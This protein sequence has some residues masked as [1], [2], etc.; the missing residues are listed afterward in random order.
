M[1]SWEKILLTTCLVLVAVK[2][3]AD[4]GELPGGVPELH[5]FV[6]Q[7]FTHTTDN[8]VFGHSTAGSLD[9]HELGLATSWR[10]H[11]DWLLSAQLI[12]RNAGEV[13][14][15]EP[16]LDYALVDY[17]FQQQLPGRPGLSLGRIRNP[18]G[19]Y[20]DTRDAPFA[21]PGIVLPQTVYLDKV[22]DLFL[23]LDGIQLHADIGPGA[24]GLLCQLNL[25]RAHID[26]DTGRT[27]MGPVMAGHT[28]NDGVTWV[29]R[30]LYDWGG[31]LQLAL[32]AGQASFVLDPW[33]PGMGRVAGKG[34]YW[35]LSAQYHAAQ[36][37]L[38]GEYVREE[39]RAD[40]GLGML[41]LTRLE[42][43]G[44][45][46]QAGYRP[47]PAWEAF[48]RYEDGV[49][50]RDLKERLGDHPAYFTRGWVTGLRWDLHPQWML[51][52]E[53]AL[54]RGGFILSPL[55]NPDGAAVVEQW[56]MLSALL[57]FRF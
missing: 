15:G 17:S 18:F 4:Q 6:G 1:W 45:Y 46:L 54:Y 32:S 53:Y 7:G 19:L 44:W 5:G 55:D 37:S 2:A 35:L 51:R 10:P 38:T 42:P 8:Q 39:L 24:H 22:R 34:T 13:D 48:L 36:W 31:R 56:N 49:A 27:V 57:A 50:D 16:F 43:R 28:D 25:G 21:R 12:S 11:G 3:G 14:N 52:C 30:L 9:F 23:S 47:S 20:N 33:M 29:G 41:P 40:G 26:G